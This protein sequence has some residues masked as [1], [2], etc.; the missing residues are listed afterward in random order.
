MPVAPPSRGLR[1]VV[2]PAGARLRRGHR[3]GHGPA[4]DLGPGRGD[5]RFAPLVPPGRAEP[6]HHTYIATTSLAALLDSALHRAAGT[7]PR[8]HVATLGRWAE[9]EVVLRHDVRLVDL[10]DEQLQRL[11]LPRTSLVAT[12]AEH[13]RCTRRWA[14]GLHGRA[15]GGHQT[16]GLVW[17]S[18]QLELQVRALEARPALRDVLSDHPAEVAVL[19]SPPASSDLLA[20]G[21]GGLGPLAEGPGRA[22]V[23]DLAAWL[24]IPLL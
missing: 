11:G 23:A 4:D 7:A 16:H 22:Y 21:E 2:W 5:T 18:R 15:I 12:G 1:T 8:V 9:A 17:H 6:V 19:W 13:H 10:R 14:G 3:P 24:G 20:A